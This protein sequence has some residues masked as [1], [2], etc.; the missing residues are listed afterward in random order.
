MNV[1]CQ[2]AASDLESGP[3]QASSDL[4]GDA[5]QASSDLAGDA[6]QASS[7]LAGDAPQVSSNLAGDDAP[8]AS[9]DLAGDDA[10]QASS[11]PDVHPLQ[12]SLEGLPELPGVYRFLNA[13]GEVLY[14]GK[15]KVLK[16]RVASYFVRTHAQ[17]RIQVMI[18]QARGL[19]ITVTASE[20]D[21]LVLEANLIR[22]LQPRYNVLLKD[23]KSY[24]YLHLTTQQVFPRLTL[25]RGGR[26]EAGKYFGPYPSVQSVRETLKYM[27]KIFPIRQCEDGQFQS[28]KRPCL[29]YQIRR[30]AAPC[31]ARVAPE[32]YAN[33]IREVVLFLEGRDRQLVQE[34]E[35][36]MWEASCKHDFET[37]I[38]L[39]DRVRAI[40]HVQEQRRLDLEPDDDLDVVCHRERE[41]IHA[42]QVFF[43]R[44]G[45]NLGNRGF[46]PENTTGVPD[47]EVLEAF[48]IQF[49]ADKKPPTE[50]LVNLATPDPEWLAHAL[51]TTIRLPQRGGKRRILEMAIANAEEALTRRLSGAAENRRRLDEL[52]EIL[53]LDGPLE[54]IEACDVS[55]FQD[56]HVV[57]S[58]VVF[59]PSGFNKNSYRRYA[60]TDPRLCDDTARM[61]AM[62]RRRFAALQKAP[63][64]TWPDLLILDG[65]LGQLHAVMAVAREMQME[66]VAICAMAKGVERN[67]GKER[68]F[69]PGKEL[70]LILP[71]ESPVLFLLQNIRDEA[72]RFAVGYHRHKRGREQIRS[73]LDAIPGVGSKRKQT[74]VRHF[75]SV[76]NLRQA[77]VTELAAVKGISPG[78]A[79]QIHAFLHS[80]G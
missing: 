3:P 32:A 25:Y 76:K 5:P 1:H 29:Q 62:L 64:E 47:A 70:P 40:R 42:V 73:G 13:G 35:K 9:S 12:A 58:L 39:R 51:G 36:T 63:P 44:A 61:A 71:P 48:L 60:L 21:A 79:E 19:E 72:H 28:R 57:G 45:I 26:Q 43:I 52:A 33:W 65:G 37:A 38:L 74:L 68:L 77:T 55:H 41:G 4:A 50:I 22:Q 14:V 46:F 17:L 11:G 7:D 10:P 34:L 67:A 16:R 59:G 20:N 75:G 23:S 27:Q 6:P 31:C 8:Q 15:A 53:D 30:C 54:R 24:P 2:Q 69:L 56:R 80:E 78:L 66:Q 18:Q 49:Y